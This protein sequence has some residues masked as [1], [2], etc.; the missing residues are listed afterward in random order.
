MTIE[1][2][3]KTVLLG[4]HSSSG[5]YAIE[6]LF[7]PNLDDLVLSRPKSRFVGPAEKFFFFFL[8]RA[9]RHFNRLYCDDVLFFLI[10]VFSAFNKMIGYIIGRDISLSAARVM[11]LL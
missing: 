11:A 8:K 3:K 5:Y 2:R 6:F 9:E 10:P 1:K 7:P 4:F